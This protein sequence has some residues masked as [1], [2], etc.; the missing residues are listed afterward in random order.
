MTEGY[1]ESRFRES[2][3]KNGN[4]T[5]LSGPD[6]IKEIV[7]MPVIDIMNNKLIKIKDLK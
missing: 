6:R 3:D 5:F 7:D 4:L 1:V 2:R